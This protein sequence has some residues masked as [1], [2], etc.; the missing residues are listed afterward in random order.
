MVET[1]KCSR[2]SKLPTNANPLKRCSKCRAVTYC[3]RE[4]QKED[5]KAHKKLC[6]LLAANATT[7]TP[8]MTTTLAPRPV[9]TSNA[10]S[11]TADKPFHKLHSKTWLHGRPEKDAFKLL[12]DTYRLRMED[13]YKFEGGAE[14]DSVYNGSPDGSEGFK[15]FLKLAESRPGVLPPWWSQAKAEECLQF[16]MTDDW[17]SLASA[18]EKADLIK[19]Y[20][21]ALMPMQLRMFGEQVY[22]TGPGG[23]SGMPMLQTQMA[24]ENGS[25]HF[26]TLDA[27]SGQLRGNR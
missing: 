11:V 20:D 18:V 24:M 3:S 8:F 7:S 15:R 17:A 19:H 1:P 27:T 12:I 9:N 6:A 23:M 26:T 10:L 4:C 13:M 5:W 22:G 21:D 25:G 14:T 2:C 16:G